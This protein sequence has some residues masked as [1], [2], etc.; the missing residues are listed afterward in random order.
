MEKKRKIAIVVRKG[1]FAEAEELDVEYYANVGWKESAATV[2]TM[3]Q[4]YW[5]EEYKRGMVKVIAKGKLKDDR[6]DIE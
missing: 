6:D 2:E 5:D 1:S 3:R 4:M